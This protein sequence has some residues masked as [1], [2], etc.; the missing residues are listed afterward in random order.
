MTVAALPPTRALL[1]ARVLFAIV[2]VAA[3]LAG[4]LMIVAP[5]E[6]DR[7]FSWPIGPPPVAALVGGFY[8]ASAL[9]FGRAAVREDWPGAR[10]L[11]IG[12]LALTVPTVIATARHH[13]LFDLDRW[14]A[15]AW[16][17][18]FVASPIAFGTILYL[19]RG[20]VARA[21]RALPAWVVT[22]CALEAIGYGGLAIALWI[23]PSDVADVM[24]FALPPMSGR[25]L[26]C[27][28]A[29]LSVLACFASV[30][31]RWPEAR[32]SLLALTLWPL[33]ASLTAVRSWDDLAPTDRRAGYLVVA[34]ALTV[35]GAGMVAASSSTAG[36]RR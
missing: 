13:D 16:V 35:V 27:W 36:S 24:P 17:V 34:V 11:C 5:D 3:G 9:L 8:L 20:R 32:T 6:T 4:L 30:R 26:G 25:F 18:L 19:Q 14:Q 29:F 15:V 2:A 33:A 1:V 22:V 10:G 28:A 7:Y 12:V 23:A 31:R 21:G